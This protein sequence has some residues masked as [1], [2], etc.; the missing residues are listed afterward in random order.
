MA[1]AMGDMADK[2]GGRLYKT[3][4]RECTALKETQSVQQD[5]FAYAPKSN[6]AEGSARPLDLKITGGM[7][8]WELRVLS[9]ILTLY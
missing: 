1:E 4:I 8:K 6:A 5:I 3:F 2:I 7:T 9:G